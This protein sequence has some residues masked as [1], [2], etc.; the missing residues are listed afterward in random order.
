MLS[1]S[2]AGSFLEKDLFFINYYQ[3]FLWHCHIIND[4]DTRL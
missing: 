3:M 2:F 1:Q 4:D